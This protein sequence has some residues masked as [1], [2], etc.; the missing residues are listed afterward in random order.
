MGRFDNE[1]MISGRLVASLVLAAMFTGTPLVQARDRPAALEKLP[2]AVHG[3]QIK[4]DQPDQRQEGEALTFPE[5]QAHK[6]TSGRAL[7][8]KR[9]R[10]KKPP[11]E[12]LVKASDTD[13]RDNKERGMDCTVAGTHGTCFDREDINFRHKYGSCQNLRTKCPNDANHA[14]CKA[15]PFEHGVTPSAQNGASGNNGP[16]RV[17]GLPLRWQESNKTGGVTGVGEG[18]TFNQADSQLPVSP[19]SDKDCGFTVFTKTVVKAMVSNHANRPMV[20]INQQCV[21]YHLCVE[22][23]TKCAET[24]C[25]VKKWSRCVSPAGTPLVWRFL[26]DLKDYTKMSKRTWNGVEY[27]YEWAADTSKQMNCKTTKECSCIVENTVDH[28]RDSWAN[29]HAAVGSSLKSTCI[30]A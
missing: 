7:L 13:W 3:F 14:A 28:P 11:L 19:V 30:S 12:N 15:N 23:K 4:P 17:R 29:L 6:T 26:T 24:T 18:N 21:K 20:C 1:I 27:R 8:M 5:G 22:S 9:R 25:T 2:P 10:K 16:G